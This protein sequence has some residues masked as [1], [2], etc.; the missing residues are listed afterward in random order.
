[1]S[2]IVDLFKRS[3]LRS[4][5]ACRFHV[6]NLL[7]LALLSGHCF[8]APTINLSTYELSPYVG[9]H[10]HQQGAITEIVK[11]S[12]GQSSLG[13]A[14]VQIHAPKRAQSL[15]Y[16]GITHA[17]FPVIYDAQ[18][19]KDFIYS[20]PMPGFQ[21]GLLKRTQQSSPINSEGQGQTI[22]VIRGSLSRLA[23]QRFPQ[24]RIVIKDDNQTLLEMLAL[25]RLD[26]VFI[27]K[28][29]A[30]DLMVDSIPELIGKFDFD[31]AGMAPLD[32]HVAFNRHQYNAEYLAFQFNE[33]LTKV[34]ESGQLQQILYSHGLYTFEQ[35]NDKKVIRI[36]T[37]ENDDMLAMQR[38]STHFENQH[39]DI[40]L[41]WHVLEENT[42]RR[43]LLSDLAIGA[44]QYDV[45]T[46]GSLE[47]STWAPKGWLTPF[48]D[49]PSHYDIEDLI[50]PIRESLSYKGSLM[51]LPFYGETSFTYYRTDLF[52]KARLKMAEKPSYDDILRYAQAIHDPENQVYGVCLRGKAGWG[53][54]MAFVSTMVNAYGGQWVNM[55]WQPTMTSKPWKQ[56]ISH[57]IQLL[58]N[59]GPPNAHQNGYAE[60]LELFAAGHC[61]IWIDATV[62]AGLLYDP[63]RSKVASKVAV[64]E[65]PSAVTD[66]GNAWLWAWSLAIPSS[67]K[68]KQ[69]AQQLITWAT[70]KQY[71][72]LVANTFGWV[73]VPPGT[74]YSTYASK[75]YQAIAPFAPLVM[76]SIMN[77]STKDSTLPP[78]PYQGIQYIDINEFPSLG[79]E[80]G[81]Q[82]NR[83]L[84]GKISVNHSLTSSQ[85]FA[86]QRLMAAGYMKPR[87]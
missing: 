59:Y 13:A 27:D 2:L 19:A 6:A 40:K 35:P 80:V 70:S 47:A 65:A 28:F 54:N 30:A 21:P 76:S 41:E 15:A 5:R 50:L 74:R 86:E 46:I 49:L 14:E 1:M 3:C 69:E 66:K 52:E 26:F 84:T 63:S 8:A 82:I 23:P 10:L 25:G 58:Q 17:M 29:T 56:A 7:G 60:N 20:D 72:E 44:G 36:A 33:G 71:I 18:L 81:Y 85:V 12:I 75:Q 73:A 64:T 68:L 37:V 53:E 34:R 83:A 77:A 4:K 45:L 51:A 32:F 24:A 57:Y 61:G 39:P 87:E 42:L 55:D 67:S 43:R 48:G 38:L 78:S 62:A 9:I 79:T 31:D 22:G 11:A 16:R